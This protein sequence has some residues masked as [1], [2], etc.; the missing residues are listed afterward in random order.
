M[1]N[2]FS[3]FFI[4]SDNLNDALD[5]SRFPDFLSKENPKKVKGVCL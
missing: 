3:G 5:K 2:Y 1:E 4:G